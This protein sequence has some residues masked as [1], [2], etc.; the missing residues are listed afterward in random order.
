MAMEGLQNWML[1]LFSGN[2]R[3]VGFRLPG[4]LGGCRKVGLRLPRGS[5]R[6]WLESFCFNNISHCVVIGKISQCGGGKK[7]GG[8]R[9]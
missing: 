8:G 4:A 3:K 7:R 6:F 2:G 9:K 5:G 1:I